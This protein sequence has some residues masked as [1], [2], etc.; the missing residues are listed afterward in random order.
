MHASMDYGDFSGWLDSSW[1][2]QDFRKPYNKIDVTGDNGKL[3]VTD[4]E[5]RW[6][7][8]KSHAGYAA[9]WYSKNITDLYVPVRMF[10]GD[11][12]FTRQADS[13]LEAIAGGP[14]ARCAVS[15]GLKTQRVLEAIKTSGSS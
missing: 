14:P 9:G 10:V 6:L 8:I 11:I 7:I 5:I 3:I 2:M 1:S 4:S 13:F 15:D 12:M